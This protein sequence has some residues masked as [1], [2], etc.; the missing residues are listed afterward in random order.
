M[1]LHAVGDE[2][3]V[4]GLEDWC[5]RLHDSDGS[6]TDE[7]CLARWFDSDWPALVFRGDVRDGTR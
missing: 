3:Q 5:Q 4:V 2:E 7:L 1:D 6:Y